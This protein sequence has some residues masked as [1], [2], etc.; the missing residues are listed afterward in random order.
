MNHNLNNNI[1]E[2]NNSGSQ[3]IGKF[4]YSIRGK[5]I[6]IDN[7]GFIYNFQKTSSI[8]DNWRCIFL[9]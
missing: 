2:D 9:S 6:F 3:E 5:K 8:S 1:N 7:D 4:T